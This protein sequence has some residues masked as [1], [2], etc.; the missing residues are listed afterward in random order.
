[1]LKYSKIQAALRE[2]FMQ[3]GKIPGNILKRS[4]INLIGRG[5]R[6]GAD[7][8]CMNASGTHVL[9]A[10]AAGVSK[11]ALSPELA[12]YKAANNIW[13][14]GGTLLGIEAAFILDTA[15]T[16]QELK[17]L[18]RK[19]ISAC[20]RCGTYLAGG[21]TEV[22]GAA[23]RTCVAVTAVGCGDNVMSLKSIRPGDEIVVTK[24]LGL[25]E[26]AMILADDV[27]RERLFERYAPRYFESMESCAEW[28]TVKEEAEIALEYGV[29]AMHDVSD[30]GIYGALWDMA[31][32]AGRGFE[33][34]SGLIPFKQETVEISTFF[35][36]DAYRMK[37]S[38]SLIIVCKD[39]ET[40]SGR[41][42]EA[43][44]PSSVIGRFTDNNDKIIRN[45][46]EI[47]YLGRK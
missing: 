13:A 25:E 12:V 46:D 47:S 16:E 44:I 30:G 2:A 38:G 21:H 36:I 45:E 11:N 9:S 33:I 3:E 14:A 40:L 6:I 41:L 19:V 28:L 8:A 29:S 10:M 27:F 4:V 5:P 43:G 26:T 24:W 37:S 22:S 39:G 17:S 1:M 32:G 7:C 20:E 35:D 42:E 31:E 15:Y 23:A 34:D 18:T